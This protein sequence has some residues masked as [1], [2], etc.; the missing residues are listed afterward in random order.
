MLIK[1]QIALSVQLDLQSLLYAEV[2]PS[3]GK[4]HEG[5]RKLVDL[6]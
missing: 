4:L 6:M 3:S 5:I 2:V 1:D